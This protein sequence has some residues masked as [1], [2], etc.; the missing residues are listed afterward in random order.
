MQLILNQFNPWWQGHQVPAA[1]LGKPRQI[2]PTLYPSLSLR[3]MTFITG[4]RRVGKTTLIFQL[5]DQLMRE[6]RVAPYHVLY[7]SFDETRYRLDEILDFYQVNILQ[8]DLRAADR[9]YIFFDE[10]QKLSHWP[11]QVKILYDLYPNVKITLSGSA[12]IIMKVKSRES[13]A[14]RFFDYVIEPLDFP[15]YLAFK[16]I[17]VDGSREG[18]FQQTLEREFRQFLKTGGFIEAIPFDDGQLVRY[19]K[20]S[21]LERV[22]YRDIPEVF[23]I[24]MPDLLLRLL[25][26]MA[27]NPG[28][29]L[30]YKNL[31]SDLQ[32]DQRTIINYLSYLEYS[33][34]LQKLY[35]YSTNLLSSEKKLKRAYL[36]NTG[37]TYALAGE[38]KFPLLMEQ[39]WVN[40]LKAKYFYRSPQKDE[41]DL[42]HVAGNFT[43][44]I[45]I[46][47]RESVSAK[48]AGA[49]FKF[50]RYFGKK[51]GLL[52]SLRDETELV[53]NGMAVKVLPY[54]KYWSIRQWIEEA[55]A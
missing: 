43:L 25:N 13:L 11:E 55:P 33:F 19:F 2:L 45:E 29:Y 14:G 21:I 5:V 9:I 34:L 4:L 1:L 24:A 31:A 12:N 16:E 37:F 28:F 30:E 3:Q 39:F 50:L 6:N 46:K 49:L 18:V 44:P 52:I 7:F 22:T 35:N 51:Q 15:E 42:V 27:Q 10:I 53:N 20:E 40:F 48:D 38:L 41:V 17:A 54:W 26:I 47:M 8:K 32:F 36:A 23:S